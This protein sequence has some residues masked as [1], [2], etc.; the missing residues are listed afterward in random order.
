MCT[1]HRVI[2]EGSTCM[3]IS[4]L[5]LYLPNILRP[6]FIAPNISIRFI[7]IFVFLGDCFCLLLLPT[8]S[9]FSNVLNDNN[10]C[11]SSWEIPGGYQT[12]W[13]P[14]GSCGSCHKPALEKGHAVHDSNRHFLHSF[15]SAKVFRTGNYNLFGWKTKLF[16]IF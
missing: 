2:T 4:L 15:Q 9:N 12:C 5:T 16:E 14:P 10:S 6:F 13:I 3:F 11:A 8:S 7:F 1:Y